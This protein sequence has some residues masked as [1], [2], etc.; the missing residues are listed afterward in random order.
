MQRN[1]PAVPVP[2]RCHRDV[3]RPCRAGASRS[4]MHAEAV[5]A[6]VARRQSVRAWLHRPFQLTCRQRS[7]RV[8]SGQVEDTELLLDRD[9]R[10]IT[11]LLTTV[12]KRHGFMVETAR[13]G[14]RPS[15][16]SS[17][18][19]SKR[20]SR[21]HDAEGRRLRSPRTSRAHRPGLPEDCVIVL[22]ARANTDLRKLDGHSV[23]RVIRKPFDLEELVDAVSECIARGA[24]KHGC[25]NA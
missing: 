20:S 9:D 1:V 4:G 22:T 24:A 2:Q 12:L 13:N 6:V 21:P 19:A 7:S 11:T 25:A 18:G 5:C 3:E 16:R 8:E 23:F 17:S 10:A 15:P 14:R